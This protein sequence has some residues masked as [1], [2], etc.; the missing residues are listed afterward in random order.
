MKFKKKKLNA[1][2]TVRLL[3]RIRKGHQPTA[4]EQAA[5]AGVQELNLVQSRVK[6]LEKGAA[7]LTGL[8]KLHLEH[9]GIRALPASLGTLPELR[10]LELICPE[11][12]SLP[13]S[14]KDL[15]HLKF[16]D[17]FCPLLETLPPQ[18]SQLPSL[19][20]LILSS[21]RIQR[22]T[23]RLGGLKSLRVLF[24]FCSKLKALP[25][26][27]GKLDQ[28]EMLTVS[29]DH[30][31]SVPGT[32]GKLS[33]LRC[34][35]IQ[36]S[37]THLPAK[38]KNLSSLESLCLR[39]TE[40]TLPESLSGL[41]K[42]KDLNFS[43]QCRHL[44]LGVFTLPGLKTLKL[45]CASLEG[46][47]GIASLETL[48]SLELSSD[49]LSSLPP[50]LFKL[51]EL[52]RL[53]LSC[54]KLERLP[55][56]LG[57][58]TKLQS[59]C[60]QAPLLESL[61]SAITRLTALTEL[62]VQSPGFK[63]LP[64]QTGSLTALRE[65]RVSA[66]ALRRLPEEIGRLAC[67]E[68]LSLLPSALERLP[69]ALGNLRALRTLALSS[70]EL[71]P[72]LDALK[73]LQKLESLELHGRQIDAIPD[74]MGNLT[75]LQ[76]LDVS[77]TAVRRLPDSL[78][79]LTG[80]KSLNFTDTNLSVLPDWIVRLGGLETLMAGNTRLQE[81]PPGLSSLKNLTCL[82]LDGLQLHGLPRE[83]LDLNMPFVLDESGRIDRKGILLRG[84]T[85]ATQPISLFEQPPQLIREYYDAKQ[86][87]VN[88]AKVIFLG[89]GS[90]GKTYTILRMLNGCRQET[91]ESPY[92]TTET[93]GILITPYHVERDGRSFDIHFWDFG[94]Q[95]IM[96]SMH[97]C[98]LTER[99]CYVVMVS[100]RTPDLT[101]GRARYWLRNIE[102]FA[103]NAPVI[104]AVNHWGVDSPH[105]GLDVS[106]LQQEFPNLVRHVPYSAM[107]SS[108]EEFRRLEEAIVE[109]AQ[110]LDSCNMSFPEQWDYIRQELLKQ[111]TSHTYYIGRS[112]YYRICNKYGLTRNKGIRSW[113]LEWF[114]DLGVCFSYHQ[115]SGRKELPDYKILDPQWLT[116]AIYR[117]IFGQGES[118]NGTISVKEIRRILSETGSPELEERGIPCLDG[119]SYSEE[120][121]TYVLEIMRKF[122]VSYQVS[123]ESEF[124]PA[125]CNENTPPC[126][127]PEGQTHWGSVKLCYHYLPDSV[128]HQL[129]IAAHP[130]LR[131]DRCWRKG[132]FLDWSSYI[133]EQEQISTTVQ[134][135]GTHSEDTEL[136]IDFYCRKPSH[137]LPILLNR[138]LDWIKTIN[139]AMNLQAEVMVLAEKNG[140]TE[141]FSETK[142]RK[143]WD[144]GSREMQGEEENYEIAELQKKF[145]L[146]EVS[147]SEPL[148][149]SSMFLK[150]YNRFTLPER[151]EHSL[152]VL[153]P[154]ISYIHQP[155]SLELE[156]VIYPE[157]RPAPDYTFTVNTDTMRF[158]FET[159]LSRA[160]WKTGSKYTSP[161]DLYTALTKK[162]LEDIQLSS[163]QGTIEVKKPGGTAS[164]QKKKK[165][166]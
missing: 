160:Y 89:D 165:K 97:R 5:L 157:I 125:L 136:L 72:P 152:G 28:L 132:L 1:Q 76:N 131:Q 123:N 10:H 106:R 80:L 82:G 21:A 58:L 23:D 120:E 51:Q 33:S 114:N 40:V 74:W 20:R 85:L 35:D 101:T 119:V 39:G 156:P 107:S 140:H 103:H 16:L 31:G 138:L 113:L 117:I 112:D 144:R 149:T 155:H 47:D 42:L 67:L 98:F 26:E 162:G 84:A 109:Q 81:L 30:L 91:E 108:E 161:S 32:I 147:W 137:V 92:H 126:L 63:T 104:L 86:I 55:G 94:G 75:A 70:D 153:D 24:I 66:P 25:A 118:Y 129:M 14:I 34:L 62:T 150:Y 11:L 142:I 163:L 29:A 36:S 13:D 43:S 133:G 124:I 6:T 56:E 143:C 48:Q 64:S 93:H 121:C 61:P 45:D 49:E 79:R 130:M 73:N 115:D 60:I 53:S 148:S 8:Q 69:E 88:E 68:V 71:R 154:V 41:T 65:L 102:S 122:K 134:M 166:P 59:L 145:A 83:L 111:A 110:K 135:T 50:G 2:E 128:V 44:P 17:I 38:F 3:E 90:V 37:A 146:W 99:T 7:Y 141:W 19:E 78:A 158:L 54:A 127:K 95:D 164:P 159:E 22:L 9:R 151:Y 27:I 105:T 4:E 46:L 139:Q 57:N 116:S 77:R 96:H 87:P 12:R 18:F 52:E 100:T 15:S